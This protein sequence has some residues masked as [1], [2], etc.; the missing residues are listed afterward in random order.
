ML[1]KKFLEETTY[2]EVLQKDI[3]SHDL[4]SF[5]NMYFTEKHVH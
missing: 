2:E 5:V 3:I 4:L 1:I